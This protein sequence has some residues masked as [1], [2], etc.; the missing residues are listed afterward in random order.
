MCVSESGACVR[1]ARARERRLH[2]PAG[3]PVAQKPG[4]A[5]APATSALQPAAAR[6]QAHTVSLEDAQ[7]LRASDSAN[8]SDAVVVAQQHANLARRQ[9]L[10]AELADELVNLARRAGRP[11]RE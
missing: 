4:S 8:L 11:A 1:S 2:A 5:L 6:R 9:A 3:L 7:H 10:L